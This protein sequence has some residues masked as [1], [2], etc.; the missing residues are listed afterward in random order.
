MLR[1]SARCADT[2]PAAPAFSTFAANRLTRFG[3]L[4][5][6]KTLMPPTRFDPGILSDSASWR[7]RFFLLLVLLLGAGLSAPAA[8][9][10]A[11]A[12]AMVF[13][14]RSAAACVVLLPGAAQ[15]STR[16]QPGP[17]CSACA[18]MQLALLCRI[19]HMDSH[20]LGVAGRAWP[21][22]HDHH[23]HSLEAASSADRVPF[24]SQQRPLAVGSYPRR[25]CHSCCG[26]KC[27]RVPPP[28]KRS[29]L[30]CPVNA[31]CPTP[32]PTEHH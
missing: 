18:G 5:N 3:S 10:A 19:Q 32:E 7:L 16:C 22:P 31:T 4:S 29:C 25:Q 17:G 24:C 11:A 13:V 1:K 28:P 23:L 27:L 14:C 15:Q 9:A 6:A 30:M 2:I 12:A 21:E 8:P 20:K 26:Q